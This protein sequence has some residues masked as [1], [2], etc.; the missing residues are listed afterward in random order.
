MKEIET[1]LGKVIVDD[2]VYDWLDGRAVNF[3]GAGY[4]IV[5]AKELKRQVYLHRL[6]NDTPKG[7]HTD[8]I[9]RNKLDCRRANLRTVTR[10]QNQWNRDKGSDG[11]T[12][13]YKGVYFYKRDKRW[14]S[15]ICS[16]NKVLF[17]GSF[18]TEIEAA[19]RYN[20]FA[21]KL[22]GDFAYQNPL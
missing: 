16:D 19:Q 2:D 5:R 10:S 21:R 20:I 3:A 1:T 6:V 14:V 18:K 7:C 9:N 17:L 8:H 12:S 4:P 22:H 11:K 13:K 15:R